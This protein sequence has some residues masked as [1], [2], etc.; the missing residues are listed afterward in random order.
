MYTMD[1]HKLHL[2]GHLKLEN[3]NLDELAGMGD[4]A[5]GVA[6]LVSEENVLGMG[7]NRH[8]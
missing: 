4:Q 5:A 6:S 1:K 7:D 3:M 8:V 2:K